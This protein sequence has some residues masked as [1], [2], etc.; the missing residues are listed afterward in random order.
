MPWPHLPL[1]SWL[2]CIHSP[3]LVTLPTL[4][5]SASGLHLR[6]KYLPVAPLKYQCFHPQL[7][8][9]IVYCGLLFRTHL[10]Y[11][12][13]YLFMLFILHLFPL[14]HRGRNFHRFFMG[15]ILH[16]HS[17]TEQ[18]VSHDRHSWGNHFFDVHFPKS[19]FL[20]LDL[21]TFSNTKIWISGRDKDLT[22][23]SVK[24]FLLGQWP[25]FSFT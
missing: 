5:H 6:S 20:P 1:S 11:C 18:W 25:W 16:K 14:F 23:F 2:H 13:F 3:L 17:L 19:L 7:C 22:V 15:W 12:I 4:Q 24:N 8:I 10:T 21:S 9:S